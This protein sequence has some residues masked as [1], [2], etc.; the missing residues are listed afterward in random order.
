MFFPQ[1]TILC[2][3]DILKWAIFEKK[4]LAE[5]LYVSRLW[6]RINDDQCF[7]VIATVADERNVQ[8]EIL[9]PHRHEYQDQNYRCFDIIILHHLLYYTILYTLNTYHIS[10]DKL[11]FSYP[12][13]VHIPLCI[14]IPWHVYYVDFSKQPTSCN[15]QPFQVSIYTFPC[16]G[17]EFLGNT[18]P[19]VCGI[20]A[21]LRVFGLV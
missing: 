10:Y 12:A 3:E 20:G 9:R 7:V 17:A 14:I 6:Q 4:V 18:H 16:L 5:G 13:A 2:I 8:I 11:Y 1:K 21:F 19:R 15:L